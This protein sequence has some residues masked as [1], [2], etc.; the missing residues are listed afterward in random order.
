MNDNSIDVVLNWLVGAFILIAL[1]V[2][3]IG[4]AIFF[5]DFTQ[6]LKYINCEIGRSEG[7]RRRYWKKKRRRLWLSLLPFVKY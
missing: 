5:N 7:E 1:V 6:E 3:L 2:L 4:I